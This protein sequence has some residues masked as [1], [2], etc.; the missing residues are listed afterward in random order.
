MTLATD[1]MTHPKKALGD[2]VQTWVKN[3]HPHNPQSATGWPDLWEVPKDAASAVGGEFIRA[4]GH[5]ALRAHLR[6]KRQRTEVP[7]D[8]ASAV[9]GEFIR[10]SGHIT[11]RA[12]LRHKRQ[13]TEA[14]NET[15]ELRQRLNNANTYFR[16]KAT[17][18]LVDEDAVRL[19]ID[20]YE[21]STIRMTDFDTCKNGFALA[22]LTAANFCEVGA[23]LIYITEGGQNFIEWLDRK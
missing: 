23:N 2:R 12:P 22:R 13:R 14:P 11:L 17:D 5:I 8:A 3:A 7:K 21:R 18:V 16:R 10:A 1:N 15:E 19:L 6:H 20:L 9:G 4:S